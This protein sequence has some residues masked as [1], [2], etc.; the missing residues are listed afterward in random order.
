MAF[1]SILIFWQ[2]FP[3]TASHFISPTW[4]TDPSVNRIDIH[5]ASKETYHFFKA[6]LS[7]IHCIK[8]NHI[9]TQ[10]NCI[11]SCYAHQKKK[12]KS[13]LGSKRRKM[14]WNCK[15][16]FFPLKITETARLPGLAYTST[17]ACTAVS[18]IFEKLPFAISPH[19][20]PFW[21][22]QTFLFSDVLT[23]EY[24]SLSVFKYD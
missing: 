1:H 8:M 16:S 11:N 3:Y 9:W 21:N 6:T 20:S 17:R 5:W 2:T 15:R 10:I 14:Q 13:F 4:W 12:K 22:K 23:M 19:C 24:C 18:V 7:K